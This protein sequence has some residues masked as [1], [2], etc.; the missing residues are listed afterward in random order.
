MDDDF[1]YT[2]LGRTG[3]RVFRLGMSGT[4]RPGRQAIREALDAGINYFFCYGFDSHTIAV[5]RDL[6]ASRRQELVI[7][8]GAPN[9]PFWHADLRR[10]CEKRLR[11]LRTDA[12]DLFL[13][14]A[15]RTRRDFTPEAEGILLR[16]REEGK[17]R[18]VGVSTHSRKL[19]AELAREG[20]L[21]VL[22]VRYNAAHRKAE[23]EIFPHLGS[24]NPGLVTYTAT[25]WRSLLKRPRTWPQASPVPTAGMCYRF[26][27]SNPQVDVCMM[28]P[29]NIVQFR[30]NIAQIRLGAASAEELAF[31]RAFGD[32]VCGCRRAQCFQ[33]TGGGTPLRPSFSLRKRRIERRIC[34]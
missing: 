27:L 21:D 16:L 7:A 26:V 18:A 30:A 12:L 14:L 28:A 15:A 33:E 1:S 31:M 32:E 4:Y 24:H 23:E 8:S 2:T 22:V 13:F 11:Q 19:A 5:L 25:R 29:S 34:A 3:R 17:V 10:A 9:L 6:P 20:A